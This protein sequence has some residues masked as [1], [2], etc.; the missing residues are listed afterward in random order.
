[1]T[2]KSGSLL[3]AIISHSIFDIVSVALV[4]DISGEVV[5]L[6]LFVWHI[7]VG[8]AVLLGILVTRWVVHRMHQEGNPIEPSM[9]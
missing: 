6:W 9:L 7:F 2:F 4:P 8:F 5:F 3:P 1:M